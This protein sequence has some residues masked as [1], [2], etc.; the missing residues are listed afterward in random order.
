MQEEEG[1]RGDWI[2]IKKKIKRKRNPGT[3][4]TREGILRRSALS[5]LPQALLHKLR[6]IG[7]IGTNVTVLDMPITLTKSLKVVYRY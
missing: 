3:L 1:R 4:Q 7:T 2:G 5:Q 6:I